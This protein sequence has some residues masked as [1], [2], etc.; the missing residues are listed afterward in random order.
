MPASRS[1]RSR[2][3]RPGRNWWDRISRCRITKLDTA[4]EDVVV[5]RRGVLEERERQSK[6]KALRNYQAGTVVHGEVR[7]VTDFGAFV[8]WAVSM[9]CCTFRHD[10]LSWSEA[11]EV[12]SP[13]RRSMLRSQD[14]SRYA[15]DSLGLKQL[16]PAV[17]GSGE[18]YQQGARITGKVSRVADFG[19]FVELEPG[20]R[21]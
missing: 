9:A 16:A 4:S 18:R 21:A 20:S 6:Q 2:T 3:G 19:A 10:L 11:S 1:G 14:Q 13:G 8:D 5:D 12:V 15:E 17:D 7:T